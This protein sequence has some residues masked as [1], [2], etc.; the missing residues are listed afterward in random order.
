MDYGPALPPRLGADQPHYDNASDQPSSLSDGIGLRWH[1]LGP[2]SILT[3]TKSMTLN[4][5][6]PQMSIQVNP[7]NPGLHHLNLKN[8]LIEANTK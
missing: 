8:I 6:Q 4:R 3:L 1:R 5:G 2:K 7:M